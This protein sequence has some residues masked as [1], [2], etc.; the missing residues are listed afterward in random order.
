MGN[1][2]DDIMK[3]TKKMYNSEIQKAHDVESGRIN[4]LRSFNEIFFKAAE[5]TLKKKT[6][7]PADYYPA[8]ISIAVEAI[9]NIKPNKT[10][11][12]NTDEQVENT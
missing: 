8:V 9:K 2:R 3:L 12:G 7:R 5:T 6:G 10:K 4:F 1:L 11:E